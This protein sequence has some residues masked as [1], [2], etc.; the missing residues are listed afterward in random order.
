MAKQFQNSADSQPGSISQR[1]RDLVMEYDGRMI[2]AE[3]NPAIAASVRAW[4]R[5]LPA[6]DVALLWA[7]MKKRVLAGMPA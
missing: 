6:D 1:T 7:A 3:W 4:I 2:G 5:A